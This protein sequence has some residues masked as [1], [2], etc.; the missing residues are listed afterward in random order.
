MVIHR[1]LKLR[2]AKN[3]AAKFTV[4]GCMSASSY[5]PSI[6]VKLTRAY[7]VVL[8][9]MHEYLGCRRESAQRF[10]GPMTFKM[11]YCMINLPKVGQDRCT[12]RYGAFMR[13]S[14][15]FDVK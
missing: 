7:G 5:L 10:V 3:V 2:R 4:Y 11:Y 14:S 9:T 12:N 15:H 13:F 8:S 1:N 6:N